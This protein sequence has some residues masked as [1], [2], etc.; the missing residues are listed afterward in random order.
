[1]GVHNR[2]VPGERYGINT[3]IARAGGTSKY[4]KWLVRCDC[5]ADRIVSSHTARAVRGCMKC[6]R[7]QRDINTRVEKDPN[8]CRMRDRLYR[9]W[10]GM[11]ARCSSGKKR[12]LHSTH[13]I[14]ANIQVCDEWQ[15]DFTAF[16]KWSLANGYT[17]E[18]SI[19]RI[20]NLGNY[21]P[22]N[23]Q[24]VTRSENSRRMNLFYREHKRQKWTTF[25]IE[26]LWGTC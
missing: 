4:P 25:P 17:D 13:W 19:D 7:K 21:E 9:T 10:I 15:N 22:S 16:R 20:N 11:R 2:I 1:M 12:H 26:A 23:C 3:I 14:S 5:G 6:T 18:L 24:W 8:Y